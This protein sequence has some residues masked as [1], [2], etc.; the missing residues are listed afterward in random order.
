MTTDNPDQTQPPAGSEPPARGGR[1]RRGRVIAAGVAAAG[2]AV[3]GVPAAALGLTGSLGAAPV[4]PPAANVA[5]HAIKFAAGNAAGPAGA[6]APAATPAPP[7][8]AA[9]TTT[10][11]WRWPA[12]S[13]SPRWTRPATR[14]LADSISAD[15]PEGVAVT[16][17]GGTVYVAQTGQYSVIAVNASTGAETPVQVG[18]YPQDVAVSPDGKQVYA[19]VTGGDTGPGGS[20]TVAVISTATNTR[21]REHYRGQRPAAGGLQPGRHAGL[22]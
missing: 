19:T 9:P 21:D 20:D 14:I 10:P 13:R 4:S 8:P 22:T 6:G 3:L 12:D 15:S 16:P 18:P 2:V 11:T 17:D 7:A 1:R 5:Q